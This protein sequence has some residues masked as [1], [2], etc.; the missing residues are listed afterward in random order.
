MFCH[1]GKINRLPEWDAELLIKDFLAQGWDK[2]FVIYRLIANH[3]LILGLNLMTLVALR[4]NGYQT[5]LP[6]CISEVLISL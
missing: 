2:I 5:L 4:V 3:Q 6:Y 1:E